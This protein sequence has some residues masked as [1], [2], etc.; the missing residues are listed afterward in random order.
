VAGTTLSVRAPG[1]VNLIADHTDFNDGFV[2]PMAIDRQVLIVVGY[3]MLAGP[4]RD[5]TPEAAAER[6][7][8]Q[9]AG[10]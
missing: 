8:A 5:I 2:L 4:P 6:L 7:R 1:R 3:E 10:P 9:I